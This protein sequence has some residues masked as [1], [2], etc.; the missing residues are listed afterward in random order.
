MY[1]VYLTYC[2]SHS[3]CVATV[4]ILKCLVFLKWKWKQ[5]EFLDV[6]YFQSES[7]SR[8]LTYEWNFCWT[9][10][11]LKMRSFVPGW[12]LHN[13]TENNNIEYQH[14][15]VV[16]SYTRV[17]S[18]FWLL[19]CIILALL[20]TRCLLKW[21]NVPAG[22]QTRMRRIIKMKLITLTALSIITIE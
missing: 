17:S 6:W 20:I 8:I 7:E 12:D 22:T 4:W 21:L 1:H 10:N 11:N 16:S 2:Y 15:H 18:T 3:F 19:I 9:N 14:S 13:D 5:S